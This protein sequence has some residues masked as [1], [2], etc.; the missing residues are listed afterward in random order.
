[1]SVS[2]AREMCIR[3]SLESLQPEEVVAGNERVIRPRLTDAQF[4]Y[5]KDLQKPLEDA[6]DQ[7]NQVVFQN[8]LGS[9]GDKARRISTLSGLIAKSLGE[10]EAVAARAGLLA[11]TDLVSL[12]VGEFPELQGIMGS[13]YAKAQGE[14]S[15]IA[16]SIQEHYLPRFSGDQLPGTMTA[17]AVAIADRIDT[18]LLYTSPSPRDAHES[19]MPSSA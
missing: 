15:L 14:S 2:W 19:R 11:K 5:N 4:F 6:L 18:C 10:N 9:F 12:M 16:D 8:A 3:D 17:C 1:M 13:Y 7:L